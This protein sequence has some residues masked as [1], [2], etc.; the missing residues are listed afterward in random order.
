MAMVERV[1]VVVVEHSALVMAVRLAASVT[2]VKL[3]SSGGVYVSR[4]RDGGRRGSFYGRSQASCLRDDDGRGRHLCGRNGRESHF[5]V[6]GR[7][8]CLRGN[9]ALV[10]HLRGGGGLTSR[11]YGGGG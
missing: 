1:V 3:V 11:I 7:A 6:G 5:H 8:D 9:G 4:F 10:D 2:V